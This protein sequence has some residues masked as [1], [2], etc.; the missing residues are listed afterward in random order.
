M[1]ALG[2]LGIRVTIELGL[3][4]QVGPGLS[5]R[6]GPCSQNGPVAVQLVRICNSNVRE[7]DEFCPLGKPCWNSPAVLKNVALFENMQR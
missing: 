7:Q 2:T 4:L 6:S 3:H 1:Q 5:F